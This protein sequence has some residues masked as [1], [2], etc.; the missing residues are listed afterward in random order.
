MV[1]VTLSNGMTVKVKTVP[2]FAMA[3]I[4]AALPPMDEMAGRAATRARLSREAAWLLALPDVEVPEDW[5]FPP[6]L[7]YAGVD[8]REGEEGR[9]LDYIEF[10]L[11]AQAQDIENVQQVMYGELTEDEVSAAEDM[12]PRDGGQADI[13]A[14]TAGCG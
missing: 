2:P 13:T 10:A 3:A 9:K 4:E 11:L 6:G 14:D 5:N 1:D 7:S 8:P 12:F